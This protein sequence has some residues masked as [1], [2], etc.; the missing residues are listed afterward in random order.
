MWHGV[1]LLLWP[2]PVLLLEAGTRAAMIGRPN[3]GKSTLQRALVHDAPGVLVYDTSEE[4]GWQ[5]MPG[6]QVVADPRLLTEARAVLRVDV[7]WLRDREGWTKPGTPGWNWTLALRVPM[8][9]GDTVLVYD[10]AL[11]TLPSS[12]GHDGAHRQQQVGRRRRVTVLVGTQ[13]ANNIDTRVLR[14]CEHLFAFQTINFTDWQAIRE[15]RGIDGQVLR[16]LRPNEF[17][18]HHAREHAWRVFRPIDPTR[19]DRLRERAWTPTPEQAAR[20]WRG[21]A[22]ARWRAWKARRRGALLLWLLAAVTGVAGHWELALPACALLTYLVLRADRALRWRI[23]VECG[24]PDLSVPV[25][26]AEPDVASAPARRMRV[27]R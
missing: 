20:G 8:D 3:S 4:Q 12:G 13:L 21:R 27:L 22:E 16:V 1:R 17:A 26:L 19:P 14:L 18:Y 7:E 24:Q 9:R 10:E 25:E 2:D 11:M 6:Y 5:S 23:V 15:A